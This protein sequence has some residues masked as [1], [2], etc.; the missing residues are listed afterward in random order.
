MG[1]PETW[2][3]K[4]QRMAMSPETL[5]RACQRTARQPRR[6]AFIGALVALA[7]ALALALAFLALASAVVLALALLDGVFALAAGAIGAGHASPLGESALAARRPLRF[8]TG[9]ECEVL[10]LRRWLLSACRDVK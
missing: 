7:F 3:K 1:P 10:P 6:Y 2:A 5:A 8:Q 4:G 9:H